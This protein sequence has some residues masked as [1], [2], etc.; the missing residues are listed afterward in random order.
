MAIN[1]PNLHIILRNAKSYDDDDDASDD[2][3]D[4]DDTNI[5]KWFQV[6]HV[7]SENICSFENNQSFSWC[8]K[9]K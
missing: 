5:N 7:V 3:N 2:Y 1:F 6:R 4:D 8:Q 9:K